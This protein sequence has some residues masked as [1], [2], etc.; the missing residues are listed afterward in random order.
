MNQE[1]LQIKNKILTAIE[2]G[3]VKMRPRWHFVLQT[4]L[5][6]VG[7]IL[8]ALALLFLASFII[9]SLRHSGVWFAP[10]FGSRG[11][12]IF[13]ASLPWLLIWLSVVFV[14]ILEILVKKYSFAY[15]QPLLYSALG[16][17]LIITIGGIAVAQ[18]PLHGG[19]MRQT[20]EKH[21][22]IA[23]PF[24]R[25]GGRLG[26]ERIQAGSIKEITE[27]GFVLNSRRGDDLRIIITPATK[28]PSGYDL[29]EGDFIVVMG[30]RDDDIIQALGIKEIEAMPGEFMPF[31][32]YPK[33][34]KPPSAR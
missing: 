7:I 14:I 24:Y 12:G 19:I 10:A 31:N 33:R 3:K 8:V 21:L 11:L 18:T 32:P 30:E 25:G 34:F 1:R 15:R 6:I 16:L 2:S 17:V 20:I 29:I 27:D 13:L 26:P 23:E 5:I 4:S 22:P 28:F 9:F